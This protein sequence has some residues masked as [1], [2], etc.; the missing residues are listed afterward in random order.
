MSGHSVGASLWRSRVF[1]SQLAT[2]AGILVF[3]AVTI[4]ALVDR[5]VR[6]DLREG[7]EGEL[8]REAALAAPSALLALVDGQVGAY[9]DDLKALDAAT[10][11]RIT[12][13]EA[14]GRVLGD[15]REDPRKMDDH[16]RRP[17]VLAA[18]RSAEGVG[19]SQR[20]SATVQHEMLYV[21]RAIED[22]A[23]PDGGFV[24]VALPLT[25][26]QE[27]SGASKSSVWLGTAIGLLLSLVAGF[28]LARRRAVPIAALTQVAE[29]MR[30]GIY[31]SR[32]SVDSGNE[33]Y[34]LADTLH[35]L[36]GELTERIARISREDAQ[37]RAMLSGMI[38]GVVAIDSEDQLVFVNEAAR[39]VL[40]LSPREDLTG[41]KLWEVAPIAALEELLG[42]ARKSSSLCRRELELHR[43][44]AERIIDAQATPFR[45]GGRS[46]IVAVLHDVTDLRRLE[47]V[48]QD[49]VANVSHELKTPLTTIKGFVETLLDGAL[50][51]EDN[52]RR[53]LQRIEVNVDRLASLVTDLLSLARIESQ[54]S[55]VQLVPVDWAG[56]LQ[57]VLHRHGD[58]ARRKE[59]ELVTPEP[60][61]SLV[62]LGDR[63]AMT[64]VAD[65]LIDNA[66]KYTPSPGTVTIALGRG[67]QVG[68]LSVRDTGVGIPENDISRV[69]ERFYRVDKARSRE[70]GGTGLGLSIVKNLVVALGG[71]VRVESV[72]GEGACFEVE[73]PLA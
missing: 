70:V 22:P 54:G 55:D 2:T 31:T 7:L 45:G 9:Q 72:P 46:G 51:D 40:G 28:W 25:V 41:R 39:S 16:S 21:A 59:S 67:Q 61:A 23:L 19:V 60:D 66:I 68:V 11:L 30:A 12:L 42:M 50:E 14:S 57:E 43:L 5:Q 58:V 24:R 64:Q 38:E 56:V 63:E 1:W 8:R 44:G 18:G 37:L 17:E 73:L 35:R 48:R 71:D 4:A 52:N 65:N 29:D 62:V 36:G 33:L 15:S 69:F 32:A 20:F 3:T 6:E 10:G 47:R 49:F 13:I 34:L 27:R 53:F 26:V